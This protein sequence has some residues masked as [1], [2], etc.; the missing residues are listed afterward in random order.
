MTGPW[1]SE[2]KTVILEKI[3]NILGLTEDANEII[4]R[5]MLRVS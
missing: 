1:V 3:N 4:C 5:E 2:I